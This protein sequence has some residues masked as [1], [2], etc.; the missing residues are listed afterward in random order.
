ML[1]TSIGIMLL[2]FIENLIDLQ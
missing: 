1:I 2:Q